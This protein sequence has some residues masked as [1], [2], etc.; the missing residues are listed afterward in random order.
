[1]LKRPFTGVIAAPLLHMHDDQ[2]VDWATLE[3]YM[4]WI[5]GQHPAAAGVEAGAGDVAQRPVVRRAA[6]GVRGSDQPPL[7]VGAQ[8]DVRAAAE[9][10]GAAVVL[11]LVGVGDKTVSMASGASFVEITG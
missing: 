8:A 10:D 7:R 9:R 6:G 3:T 4:D 2:S 1:M 5:A 11:E